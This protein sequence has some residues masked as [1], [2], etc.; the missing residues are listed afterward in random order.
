MID[1]F[2]VV[3]G[4]CLLVAALC[5]L[6]PEALWVVFGFTLLHSFSVE[7]PLVVQSLLAI[8]TLNSC[9]FTTMYLV[10]L[11]FSSLLEPIRNRTIQPNGPARYTPRVVH[12]GCLAR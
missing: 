6:K 3:R 1:S 9:S 7:A 12:P 8:W 5:R 2:S 4:S 10:Y 11:A